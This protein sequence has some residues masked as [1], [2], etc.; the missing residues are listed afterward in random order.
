[1]VN[2]CKYENFSWVSVV[3]HYYIF[4]KEG[5]LKSFMCEFYFMKLSD[6]Q[7]IIQIGVLISLEDW[8]VNMVQWKLPDLP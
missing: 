1:V 3:M 5:S 8:E 4:F 7:Y 6:L 2:K